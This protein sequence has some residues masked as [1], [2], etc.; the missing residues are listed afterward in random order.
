MKMHSS[1]RARIGLL[2]SLIIP[3]LALGFTAGYGRSGAR[4]GQAT[5]E[6]T[7]S[8]PIALTHDDRFVWVA[9]PENNT[10][11]VIEVG[12]NVNR[13]RAEIQV[14]QEPRCVAI[15]PDD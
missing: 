11:S 1:A 7:Y 6:P 2:L 8:S 4:R 5:A 12:N 14:R 9:N 15:T 3:V 10:V 13:K